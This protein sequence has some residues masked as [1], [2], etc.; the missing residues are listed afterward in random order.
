[1]LLDARAAAHCG[2]DAATGRGLETWQ[3][4]AGEIRRES[5]AIALSRK[6]GRRFDSRRLQP[7]M[8]LM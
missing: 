5:L 6:R 7:S 4:I 1:M 3:R 2:E 8:H